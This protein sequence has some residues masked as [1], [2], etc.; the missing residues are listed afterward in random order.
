MPALPRHFAPPELLRL[1]WSR[2][3]INK[4]FVHLGLKSTTE[5][6]N[7][8]YCDDFRN[9]TLASRALA[10]IL[11]PVREGFV[12]TGMTEDE[13]DALIEEERQALWEEKQGHAN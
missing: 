8:L 2:S 5:N 12:K 3:S 9:T 6:Q 4:H 1:G 11:A 7:F 13:F 10:E